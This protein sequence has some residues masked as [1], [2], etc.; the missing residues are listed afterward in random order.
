MRN[1]VRTTY[2]AIWRYSLS[3]FSVSA[4]QKAPLVAYSPSV[5]SGCSCAFSSALF[6][7][8]P[9]NSKPTTKIANK[10]KHTSDRLFVRKNP[11]R[12]LRVVVRVVAMSASYPVSRTVNSR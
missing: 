6:S 5:S 9:V 7:R 11:D 10:A 1:T 2:P 3:Q 8:Y 4:S 12:F